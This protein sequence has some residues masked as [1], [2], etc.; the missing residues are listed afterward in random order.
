MRC[1]PITG[2]TL[3]ACVT[4]WARASNAAVTQARTAAEPQSGCERERSL[5]ALSVRAGALC[6]A[7]DVVMR[8]R[9]DK[10]VLR[11][12]CIHVGVV[13]VC[14]HRPNEG[15]ASGGQE[16]LVSDRQ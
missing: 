12:G 1:S 9:A 8:V 6:D 5:G 16:I 14:L 7:E 3:R 10:A 15:G 11:R 13:A 2:S 4:R